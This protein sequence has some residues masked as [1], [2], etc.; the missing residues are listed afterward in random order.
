M[1]ITELQ[2]T[3]VK[4]REQLNSTAADLLD[5]RMLSAMRKELF[6][7]FKLTSFTNSQERQE[8]WTNLQLLLDSLK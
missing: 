6:E 3:I 2:D 4:I 1:T 8:H 7:N 5:S